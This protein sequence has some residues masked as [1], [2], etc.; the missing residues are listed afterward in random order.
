VAPVEIGDPAE[1]QIYR[2]EPAEQLAKIPH[3]DVTSNGDD[4]RFID[5]A[6]E[7][8]GLARTIATRVPFLPIPLMLVDSDHDHITEADWLI[9]DADDETR[10]WAASRLWHRPLRFGTRR[11]ASC[12][13]RQTSRCPHGSRPCGWRSLK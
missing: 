6:L 4:T 5:E 3:I 13:C 10:D 11:A 2:H 1:P 9:A 7:E 8:R 12:E